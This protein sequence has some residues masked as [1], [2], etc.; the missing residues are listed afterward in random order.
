MLQVLQ[1]TGWPVQLSSGIRENGNNF[2]EDHQGDG[3]MK[4]SSNSGHYG[5]RQDQEQNW[6]TMWLGIWK[7]KTS[8]NLANEEIKMCI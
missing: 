6:S 2:S 4:S 1:T 7:K 5:E 3:K 8:E